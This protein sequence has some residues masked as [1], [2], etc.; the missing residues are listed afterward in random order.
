MKSYLQKLYKRNQASLYIILSLVGLLAFGLAYVLDIFLYD[1]GWDL[2][3]SVLL[4]FSASIFMSC[5]VFIIFYAVGI[6]ED[7]LDKI[8]RNIG[9]NKNSELKEIKNL[10]NRIYNKVNNFNFEE[11]EFRVIIDKEEYFQEF[12]DRIKNAKSEVYSVGRGFVDESASSRFYVNNLYSAFEELIINNN[13]IK[14]YRYNYLKKSCIYWLE[15]IQQLKSLYDESFYVYLGNED[16]NDTSEF[17]FSAV[18]VID[19]DEEDFCTVFLLLNHRDLNINNHG[20]DFICGIIVKGRKDL[21]NKLIEMIRQ[22]YMMDENAR[23]EGQLKEII[24][25]RSNDYLDLMSP[26]LYKGD[27]FVCSLKSSKVKDLKAKSDV[28]EDFFVRKFIYNEICINRLSKEMEFYWAYDIDINPYEFQKKFPNSIYTGVAVAKDYVITINSGTYKGDPGVTLLDIELEKDSYLNEEKM[29]Y[30]ILYTLTR[31]NLDKL[32]NSKKN[33][34][35]NDLKQIRVRS[36]YNNGEMAVWTFKKTEVS[37]P[38][39]VNREYKKYYNQGL[40]NNDFPKK[41]RNRMIKIWD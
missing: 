11:F 31:Q 4:N 7:F 16:S 6:R 23:D 15:K 25:K 24:A 17:P 35:Y 9:S 29:S 41:F 26:Y 33:L 8:G 36:D 14:V 30:G 40:Q 22:N 27:R 2:V 1:Y 34:G 10:S 32:K 38:M 19:G 39:N 5:I 18:T 37:N 3:V 12:F 13:E 28:Y 20:S 21:S